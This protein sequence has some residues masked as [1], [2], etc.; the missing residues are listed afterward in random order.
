MGPPC[1][2]GS[3]VLRVHPTTR[4]LRDPNA[5]LV[6]IGEKLATQAWY[7]KAMRR[8]RNTIAILALLLIPRFALAQA[9][10][11]GVVRDA[12]SAVLPGVR[13][14][15][16][17]PVLIDKTRTVTTDTTG[18]YRITDLPPGSYSM[19]FSLGGFS[20][21]TQEGLVV[22]G[23]GVIPVNAQLRMGTLQETVTV[24]AHSPIVD[25]MSR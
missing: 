19:T 25:T 20:S 13:V 17:S 4:T 14:D 21:V 1:F 10:I 24:T 5:L 6:L 8:L 22:S 11:A 18:Q 15:V 12:S 2:R 9:T 23:S 16:S 3:G 7:K